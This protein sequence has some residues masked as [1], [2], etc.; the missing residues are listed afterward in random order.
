MDRNKKE[1]KK[2]FFLEFFSRKRSLA[3]GQFFCGKKIV[4]KKPK[5]SD[6]YRIIIYLLI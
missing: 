6:L 5:I 4:P 2:G 1:E 3:S